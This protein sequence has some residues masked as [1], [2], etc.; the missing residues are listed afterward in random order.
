MAL[1]LRQRTANVAATVAAHAAPVLTQNEELLVVE[2]RFAGLPGIAHGGYLAGLLAT[3]L[4]GGAAEVRLRRPLRPATGSASRTPT[5]SSSS[6]A[7][8]TRWSQRPRLPRSRS[9][10]RCP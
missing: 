10:R 7:T 6:C 4:G 5:L 3:A 8:E 9:T 1:A 2:R